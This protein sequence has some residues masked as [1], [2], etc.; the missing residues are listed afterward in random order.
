[1]I[2]QLPW[3]DIYTAS[4]R[5]RVYKI[6]P[7]INGSMLMPREFQK[8]DVLIIQKMP[9]YELMKKA[10]KEKA[11]VIYDID[12][13]YLEQPNYKRMVDEADYV[14]VGSK[15]LQN[16]IKRE[17]TVI[18]DCLDWDGIVKVDYTPKKIAGWTGYGNS[19]YLHHIAPILRAAGYSIRAIVNES[20]MKDYQHGYDAR[21]WELGTVDKLL[22]EC[23]FTAY[24]LPTDDFAQAKGMNKL[25]KSW[26][27]GL[28]CFVSKMPE[29][30]RVMYEAGVDGY[31]VRRWSTFGDGELPEWQPKM[32]NYAMQFTPD[33]IS[34]QWIQ[35]INKFGE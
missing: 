28:P 32:R 20:F 33:K 4:S 19:G 11:K 2:Y 9:H 23:D 7:F 17:T 27:I 34:K 3:G 5:L 8:G 30:I 15:F 31:I 18:D 29:Y 22:A 1:M 6:R 24:Y 12:D 10:Q 21:K 14:T 16:V 26:A 13:N 25:I 35:V